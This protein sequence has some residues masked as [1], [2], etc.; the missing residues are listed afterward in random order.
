MQRILPA[1][2]DI[3]EIV[4]TTFFP[5]KREKAALRELRMT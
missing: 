5:I 2:I 4:N 3:I 1:D